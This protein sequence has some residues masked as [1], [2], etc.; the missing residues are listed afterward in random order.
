[1]VVRLIT[2][3]QWVLWRW[4]LVATLRMRLRLVA[5]RQ[6]APAEL[7]TVRFW[8]S[9]IFFAAYLI[10]S[11]LAPYKLSRLLLLCLGRLAGHR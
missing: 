5:F 6:N 3:T 1:M 10:N 2:V 7:E 9:I 4:M 8:V 11:L